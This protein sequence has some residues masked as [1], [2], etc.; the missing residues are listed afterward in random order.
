VSKTSLIGCLNRKDALTAAFA[1]EQDRSFWAWWDHIKEQRADDP[2]AL[3][4]ALLVGIAK[5]IGRPA[6]RGCPFLNL[7]TVVTPAECP[8]GAARPGSRHAPARPRR[9]VQGGRSE[10]D[11]ACSGRD[12]DGRTSI[13]SHLTRN[14]SPGR[15]G[16]GQRHSSRPAP[17][18]PPAGLSSSQPAAAS[19]PQRCASRS[20]SAHR[21]S[22]GAPPLHRGGRLRIELGS[23]REA[24]SCRCAAALNRTSAHCKT[25]R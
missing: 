10:L 17:T 22:S 7:T 18:M 24:R 12:F 2:R 6:D 15:T 1:A 25:S 23:E 14:S 8:S 3:P 21:K 13:T 4:D 9:L 11:Q 5:R 19:L 16:R 20:R